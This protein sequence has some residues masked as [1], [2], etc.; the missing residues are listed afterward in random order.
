M[1]FYTERKLH[2]KKNE[3]NY[4]E[5]KFDQNFNY[6]FCKTNHRINLQQQARKIRQ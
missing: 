1:I 4:T 3:K 6:L 2:Q 5:R